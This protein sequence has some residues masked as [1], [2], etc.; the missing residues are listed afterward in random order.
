[1]ICC[2]VWHC[3]GSRAEGCGSSDDADRHAIRI[4]ALLKEIVISSIPPL[5][6]RPLGAREQPYEYHFPP[7]VGGRNT[8]LTSALM[9]TR[10]FWHP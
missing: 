8:V 3:V 5:R 1:M 2:V 4:Y 9:L 6:S 7:T 10:S